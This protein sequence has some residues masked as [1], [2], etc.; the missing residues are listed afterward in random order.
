MPAVLRLAGGN[1]L[2]EKRNDLARQQSKQHEESELG[3]VQ[4]IADIEAEL[5]RKQKIRGG[6]SACK[7]GEEQQAASV[8]DRYQS[9]WKKVRNDKVLRLQVGLD[10]VK[11]RCRKDNVGK[12]RQDGR[13]ALRSRIV[14]VDSADSGP[15][16][17]RNTVCGRRSTEVAPRGPQ[18][19][20]AQSVEH[21]SQ[22]TGKFH[23]EL[24]TLC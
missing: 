4:G 2:C 21:D 6:D 3:D 5:R 19:R 16:L 17:P 13:G 7:G 23:K 1:I 9:C 14:G 12:C 22:L 20:S 10:D 15:Q 18:H 24:P 8:S 11:D